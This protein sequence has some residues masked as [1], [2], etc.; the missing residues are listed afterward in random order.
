MNDTI[1][2][3]GN[4]I[5]TTDTTRFYPFYSLYRFD[6]GGGGG[7]EGTAQ[8]M[9]AS[10]IES[11]NNEDYLTAERT[12]QEVVTTYPS[13][14]AAGEGVT[15]L[16]IAENW[17]GQNFDDLRTFM[18]GID[19]P[20]DSPLE[21]SW[22]EVNPKTHM[23]ESDYLTAIN[24]LEEIILNPDSEEEQI[25][26]LIDEAYCYMKLSE[27][28]EGGLRSVLP[29][30]TVQ[31]RDWRD[32]QQTV[33]VLQERLPYFQNLGVGESKLPNTYEDTHQVAVPQTFRLVA[34]P[35]PFNPTTTL[36]YELPTVAEVTLK[37]YDISGR[38]VIVLDQGA[39]EAGVYSVQW[40]GKTTEGQTVA[41]GIYIYR[42]EST[43][44]HHTGKLVLLK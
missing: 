18:N 19:I 24:V 34:Y 36:R 12:F 37:V 17:S 7:E 23:S 10:G 3:R 20:A 44:Y 5:D 11:L 35:N 43:A 42:F 39:K 1:D 28:G 30:C 33:A 2:L 21:Q 16:Y 6:Q 41:S 15:Y 13:T 27:A 31:P 14:Q 8:M 9:L 22:R 4:V 25:Y 32:Y 38:L 40:H 29:E 26:A